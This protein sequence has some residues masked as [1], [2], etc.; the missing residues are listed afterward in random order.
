M[1][2]KVIVI[3]K[4]VTVSSSTDAVGKPIVFNTLVS[5]IKL[6]G[7]KNVID[8][9]V[10]TRHA[11]VVERKRSHSL[12]RS[13]SQSPD[14]RDRRR[15]RSPIRPRSRLDHSFSHSAFHRA[16]DKREYFV[17]IRDNFCE[18]CIKNI[19]CDPSSEPSR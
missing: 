16:L 2:G 1:F 11:R 19:Y 13:R 6:I 14:W 18:F 7:L 10:F 5:V 15:G 8:I 12:D 17:M 4:F 9:H 3:T